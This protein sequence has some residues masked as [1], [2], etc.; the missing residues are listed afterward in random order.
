MNTKGESKAENSTLVRNSSA[1]KQSKRRHSM[2]PEN[3]KMERKVI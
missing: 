2:S 1:F 3:A